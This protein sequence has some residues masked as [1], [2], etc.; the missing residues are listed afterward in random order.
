[1]AQTQWEYLT[2]SFQLTGHREQDARIREEIETD[3]NAWGARGYE[4]VTVLAEQPGIFLAIF[5]K[6]RE[7]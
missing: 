1:M 6:R 4:L 5:K 2:R 7:I 3:F